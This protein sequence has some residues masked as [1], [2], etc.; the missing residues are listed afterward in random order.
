MKQIKQLQIGSLMSWELYL[1]L[2]IPSMDAVSESLLN[3]AATFWCKSRQ[4]TPAKVGV[5]EEEERSIRGCIS[6][7]KADSETNNDI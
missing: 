4:I 7:A 2:T 6:L 5:E 3:L 1:I